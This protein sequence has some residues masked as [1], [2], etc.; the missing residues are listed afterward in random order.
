[1]TKKTIFSALI[2]F[3]LILIS[4]AVAQLPD[5]CKIRIGTNLAGVSDYSRELPFVNVMKNA[6][7]WYTKGV[8]DPTYQWD[9]GYV[10][11]LTFGANGYPTHIP[12]S[13]NGSNLQHMVATVWDGTDGWPPGRYT[14]L[15]D[16][17]GDFDFWGDYSNLTFVGAN[18]YEFDYMNPADGILQ[19]TM[20]LSD[21]NDPVSNMRLLMP[22][23][24]NT[25]LTQPFYQ[26][27]LDELDPF[28]TIR[29]MDW[30]HT[31]FWGQKDPY[32]WVDP[33]LSDWSERAQVDDYTYT[34]TK[35]VPYELMIE[36]MNL[37]DADGWVCIPHTASSDYISNMAD[38]FR[39]TCEPER[40][41]YVEYSNEIWNWIF[42]QAQWLNKYGC[43]DQNISWP[44]GV[45]PY[46]QN[47]LD[48]WTTSFSSELDRITRV[49]AVQTSWLDVSERMLYNLVPTSFDAVSPTF[50]FSYDDI[51]E[52][53][54]DNL[55]TG[56]TTADIAY[57]SRLGMEENM[58]GV[59]GIKTIAD[60]LSKPLAFYEGG[61]H[62]TPT[63]FGVTPSYENAL[64]DIQRDSSMYNMY[65][66]WLD[67]IRTV[68][69]SNEAM[70]LMHF[71]FVSPRSAQYGSWGMLELV[72]Q[73]LTTIPAPKYQAIMENLGCE[74]SLTDVDV[75]LDTE[76]LTLYPNPTNG[77]FQIKGYTSDYTIRILDGSGNIF[78]TITTIANEDV[79]IN[80]SSIPSGL[81]FVAIT[82]NSNDIISLQK[83][84]KY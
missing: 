22:G 31:N 23:T 4:A 21:I 74:S 9:T 20:A 1:M 64:M 5:S 79:T 51:S 72:G 43:E 19:I 84:L 13:V 67:S 35:G 15:W 3:N 44:E 50:Y 26:E 36:L 75:L 38:L 47:T 78:Q 60:S 8:N 7:E 24:E 45:V 39:D 76:C 6:R 41:I 65:N 52:G 53:I 37:L 69:T 73:D 62:F 10:D 68:N 40:E 16:G 49:A 42:G 80:I 34:T 55:G 54:L 30:G 83:I 33:T 14:L 18:R 48:L 66:E 81:Y 71:S 59:R 77:I 70:L 28:S 25:Y 61:Q 56:A 46:I 58:D 17:T 11:S 57:H 27:W 12:Q 29:F 32:T 2:C 82:S 63:P